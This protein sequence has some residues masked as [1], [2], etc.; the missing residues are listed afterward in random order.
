MVKA[1]KRDTK[2][3][4]APWEVN[5]PDSAPELRSRPPVVKG[6]GTGGRPRLNLDPDWI[7][8]LASQGMREEQK[9]LAKQHTAKIS[10]VREGGVRLIR[11]TADAP[12]KVAGAMLY[13]ATDKWSARAVLRRARGS[14]IVASPSL[15]SRARPLRDG[16]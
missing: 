11:Y 2:Q 4:R 10:T 15:E 9:I 12:A 1:I 14:V 13:T 7:K 3:G 16:S 6:H 8:Q 5:E